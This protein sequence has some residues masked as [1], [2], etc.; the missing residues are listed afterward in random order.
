MTDDGSVASARFSAVALFGV[1]WCSWRRL[2]L[3]HELDVAIVWAVTR[4]SWVAMSSAEPAAAASSVAVR[5]TTHNA[6]SESPWNAAGWD[7]ED[8]QYQSCCIFRTSGQVQCVQHSALQ[9]L[10][11]RPTCSLCTIPLL[12]AIADVLNAAIKPHQ[13]RSLPNPPRFLHRYVPT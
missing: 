11:D 3:L 10:Q 9:N 13:G 4:E 12:H 7:D 8:S 2:E 6:R 5:E 1:S